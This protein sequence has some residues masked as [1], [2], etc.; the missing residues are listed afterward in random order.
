MAEEFVCIRDCFYGPPG[1]RQLFKVGDKLPAGWEPNKHFASTSSGVV[2]GIEAPKGP[3]DDPRSTS[4]MIQE[5]KLM[6]GIDMAGKTR[7]EVFA[8]WVEA[9]NAP[10]TG[11]PDAPAPEPEEP[12]EDPMADFVFSSMTPDQIEAAKVREIA[13]AIKYRFNIDVAFVGK[14]KH[15]L[16]QMGIDLEQRRKGA[17]A[18]L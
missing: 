1:Y 5:L 18:R 3:G 16:I 6:H 2:K 10:K 12:A 7:K 17:R 9:E 14:T 13:A 4:K 11:A 15:E 8:A